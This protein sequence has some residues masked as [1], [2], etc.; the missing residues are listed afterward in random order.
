M[1][2]YPERR[3][4]TNPEPR[5]GYCAKPKALHPHPPSEALKI[6]TSQQGMDGPRAIRSAAGTRPPAIEGAPAGELV[7]VTE[8]TLMLS[9][10]RTSAE[11]LNKA[12]L[13]EP[14]EHESLNYHSGQ[15]AALNAGLRHAVEIFLE[16]WGKKLDQFKLILSHYP[17]DA[18]DVSL[19]TADAL[20]VYGEAYRCTED[21]SVPLDK[22]IKD[23]NLRC[24][25][26]EIDAIVNAPNVPFD[27]LQHSLNGLLSSTTSL[28][29][30]D[31]Y[32]ESL[33]VLDQ[34]AYLGEE[35]EGTD[36]APRLL[37]SKAAVTLHERFH[38]DP[39]ES[40]D[41]ELKKTEKALLKMEERV[42]T[43]KMRKEK[44][45]ENLSPADA[46]RNLHAQVDFSN[47][48]LL[49]NKA[50]MA[51]VDMHGDDVREYRG[52]VIRIIEC[53]KRAADFLLQ[54]VEQLVPSVQ[55]DL[56]Q[57]ISDADATRENIEQ[58]EK[59][60]VLALEDMSRGAKTFEQ[61]ELS[62]WAEMLEIMEKI[63]QNAKEK[64]R[65]FQEKMGAK[66]KRSKIYVAA[67]ELLEAQKVH[68]HRL[69]GVES[70]LGNWHRCSE[71]Y[72]KF[73]AAFE[74]KLLS[75]VSRIEEEDEE[76]RNLENQD[77]V[78]RYE[79]FTYGAE[80]A[81]AK[82]VVQADR[83]RLQ[84][85]ASAFDQDVAFETLDPNNEAHA[86]K[87]DEAEK[88][89]EEVLAYVEYIHNIEHDRRE[90]VEPIL[91]RV[92]SYNKQTQM[93]EKALVQEEVHKIESQHAAGEPTSFGT[94]PKA[95]ET[96]VA[97]VGGKGQAL[98]ATMQHPQITARL[99]GLAH[100]EGYTEKHRKLNEEELKASEAIIHGIKKSKNELMEMGVKY[101]NSEYVQAIAVAQQKPAEESK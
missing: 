84:H 50:R 15:Q 39:V 23:F 44:A 9:T 17:L 76:L 49:M 27:S 6:L 10:D 83:M 90:E 31:R 55:K 72:D 43:A 79:M 96:R 30:L 100:E 57:V 33:D 99:V 58:L 101:K 97:V 32:A 34:V 14:F 98:P 86:K 11:V 70:I 22:L 40:C 41:R 48:L 47:D 65:Y 85:R 77:Y 38:Y 94:H 63:Q 28:S 52:E 20:K 87:I 61:K 66:E 5:T 67:T 2:Q 8:P 62:L 93:S 37:P 7:P 60:E 29:P 25:A 4:Y 69:E 12:T 1:S 91:K 24:K 74:P 95:D 71:L 42:L 89:L 51:L 82:R 53:A 45:I 75:R 54:R 35:E 3:P 18:R 88:E 64:K 56:A 46:L 13:K 73:V 68:I 81:R 21:L 16:E 26:E 92:I 59:E 78:R 36:E 19:S 80:E